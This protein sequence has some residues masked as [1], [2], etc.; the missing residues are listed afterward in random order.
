MGNLKFSSAFKS[1][2]GPV[3]HPKKPK[4]FTPPY[5]DPREKIPWVDTTHA[6]LTEMSAPIFIEDGMILEEEF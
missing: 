4:P 3:W 5:I 1:G 6:I 2:M